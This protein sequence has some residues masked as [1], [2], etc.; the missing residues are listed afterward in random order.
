MGVM[1]YLLVIRVDNDL[2]EFQ[3]N[4][5]SFFVRLQKYY[6]DFH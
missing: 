5:S 1:D 2:F 4:Q 6:F 3:S